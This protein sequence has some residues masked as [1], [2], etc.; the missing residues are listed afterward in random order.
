MKSRLEFRRQ[1]RWGG[2]G[3]GGKGVLVVTIL[4]VVMISGAEARDVGVTG[5]DFS[6]PYTPQILFYDP[7]DLEARLAGTVEPYEVLPY[8][9]WAPTEIWAQECPSIG[10]IA[11]DET[12]GHLYEAER[13][14]GEFG[15]GIIHVYELVGGGEIFADGFESGGTTVWSRVVPSIVESP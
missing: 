7:V 9:T 10:G 11:F 12:A 6:Y 13:L 14:A 1:R 3:F 8:A 5:T 15:E 4:M 2:S